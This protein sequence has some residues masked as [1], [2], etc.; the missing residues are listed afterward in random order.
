MT[1]ADNSI[2]YA[3]D[4]AGTA[5]FALSGA[6]RAVD[7][8]PDFVGMLILASCTAMGGGIFR[9]TLLKRDVG[10]LRDGNYPLVILLATVAVCL[11]PAAL[12]KRERVFKYFDAV[13][14]GV[15]T[16]VTA[17]LTW[18]TPGVSAGSVLLVA[19][20][21]G[22]AGG[23]LR[24]LM[25]H[26]PT[27]ILS[28]E[29]YVTPAIFGAGTLI[30]L[31]SLGGRPDVAFVSAM[32]CTMLVRMLAIRFQWRLPRIPGA[33][34]GE[35]NPRAAGEAEGKTHNIAET[36]IHRRDA[37]YAEIAQRNSNDVKWVP[38]SPASQT[39]EMTQAKPSRQPLDSK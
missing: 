14:L 17:S 10:F 35:P 8:R 29:L 13:G 18:H 31:E 6:L 4:L 26:K 19:T 23:V 9:D 5:G 16:A 28:N 38:A 36:Q 32:L 3:V 2:L 33:H 22:C 12:L 1:P 15:F 27:L 25:I 20:A 39:S 7:R 11:F 30:A 37:E 21:A 34:V 24:D